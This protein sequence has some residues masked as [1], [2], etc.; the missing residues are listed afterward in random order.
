MRLLLLQHGEAVPKALDPD[1]PLSTK[2]V[3]DI[4]ALGRVLAAAGVSV[5]QVLHSG[6][7]RAG[8]SAAAG[9]T[10]LSV[11]G[12]VSRADDCD[13]LVNAAVS[14]FGR[15]DALVNNAGILEP[16]APIAEADPQ[17]WQ[18]SWAV[19]V[20]GPVLMT[21]A[22]LSHLRESEGRIV[23]I[24]SGAANRPVVGWGAYCTTKAALNHLNRVL[25]L[26]EPTLTTIA[27][28]PGSSGGSRS[29]SS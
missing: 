9:G 27:V 8:Q 23:H 14:H 17:A 28:R 20:L 13:H 24:S 12:D 6:K 19:N 5:A 21:R 11:P 7:T 18:R 25:A 2:G 16:I 4:E 1:R 29:P 10:A 3:N 26:E 15:L 22:A